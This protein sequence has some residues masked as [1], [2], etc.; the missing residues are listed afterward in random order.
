MKTKIVVLTDELAKEL[1]SYPNQ[2]E[3]IRNALQ[4]YNGHITPEVVTGLRL[5][6]EKINK[7]LANIEIAVEQ[8][9]NTAN[10]TI[11]KHNEWGA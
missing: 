4:L 5:A 9:A 10:V 8:I 7:R 2:S 11:D 6:Y 1:E 3:V